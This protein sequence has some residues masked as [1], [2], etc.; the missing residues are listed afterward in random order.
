MKHFPIT[1]ATLGFFGFW[2]FLLF[3]RGS[4]EGENDA[5]LRIHTHRDHHEF[6]AAFHHMCSWEFKSIQ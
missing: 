6:S 5:C 3:P 1:F 4:E 2:S